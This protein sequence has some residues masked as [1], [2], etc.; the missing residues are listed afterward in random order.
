MLLC[1]DILA[2][3]VIGLPPPDIVTSSLCGPLVCQILAPFK[4]VT[5]F[6]ANSIQEFGV[7]TGSCSAVQA[8]EVTISAE[9]AL[10]V[11]HRAFAD[12]MRGKEIANC[13]E[14]AHFSSLSGE[15]ASGSFLTP[16]R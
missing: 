12:M 9:F 3:S 10:K 7:S 1:F 5:T 8:P 15:L 6:G 13:S 16:M 2:P 4:L 11:G 14:Y